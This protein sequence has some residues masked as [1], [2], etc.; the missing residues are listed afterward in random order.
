M[1]QVIAKC[2]G[3]QV[4]FADPSAVDLANRTPIA[5]Q[6]LSSEKVESL[7]WRGTYGIEEG[8]K[9]TLMILGGE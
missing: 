9:H 1:A 6:V 2:A 5:K 4:V 7:G 3:R 8:I